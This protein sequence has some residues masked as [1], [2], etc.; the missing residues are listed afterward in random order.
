MSDITNRNFEAAIID[1]HVAGAFAGQRY[2]FTP[3]LDRLGFWALGVAVQ[4]ESGYSPIVG[5]TFGSHPEA[6][7][8]ADG[9]NEHI[10]LSQDEAIEIVCSSMRGK[11]RADR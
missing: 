1:Q 4:D 11:R 6:K 2:A 3:V 5:K 10:G 7:A 8:W 9:L